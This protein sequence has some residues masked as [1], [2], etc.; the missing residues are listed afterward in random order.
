MSEHELKVQQKKEVHREGEATKREKYFVPAVDIFESEK[1]VTVIAEMPGVTVE[2][3]DVTLEDDV[4]TLH[5]RRDPA[6]ISGG[7]ILFQEY[8]TGNYQRRF[9]VAETIDQEKIRATVNNGMLKVVL[10]KVA[11]AQPRKIEVQIAEE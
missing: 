6:E 8:E 3:I 1:E 5:G 9:T 11:P 4:L 10:P 7:G 2:G